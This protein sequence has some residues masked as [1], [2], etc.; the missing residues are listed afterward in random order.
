MT[1]KK[2]TEDKRPIKF[3]D[4]VV[5]YGDVHDPFVDEPVFDMFLE[6]LRIIKPNVIVELGDGIDFFQLSKFS[7]D[8]ER[9]YA[10]ASDRDAFVR[11]RLAVSNAVGKKCL[12]KYLPGNHEWR[13]KE[14]LRTKASELSN[15]PELSI[16]EFLGLDALGWDYRGFDGAQN[17]TIEIGKLLVTHGHIVRKHSSYSAR[18]ILEDYGQS[19][20]V[21]HTHRLG[22]YWRSTLDTTHV[23]YEN[24]CLCSLSAGKSYVKGAINWQRGFS[25]VSVDPQTGWFRVH[26]IP[27]V[28]VPGKQVCRL[29]LN[30]CILECNA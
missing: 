30:E 16:S 7:V 15:I 5:V 4:K 11:R 20:L 8:P 23:A 6:A 18:A 29:Q 10:L 26:Q 22:S 27:I 13:L 21:G 12:R 24:G 9:R 3:F 28:K 17:P 14:Y 1:H 25:V 2:R 19:V